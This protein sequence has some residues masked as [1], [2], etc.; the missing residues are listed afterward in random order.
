MDPSKVPTIRETHDAKLYDV[1]RLVNQQDVNW[2][3]TNMSIALHPT[4]GLSA[5]YRSS[6]YRIAANG[7]Y[8]VTIGGL[9]KNDV[10]FSELDK[11]FKPKNLRKLDV[12]SL[13]PKIVR[14]LEDAKLFYKNKNWYITCVTME[15]EH[16]EVARMAV[17][18]LD[19]KCTKVT[20]F[21]KF[22]GIDANRP[23]KN[24]MMPL[25]EN[26]PFDFMYGP[27]SIVRGEMLTSWMTD[28]QLVA[29]LRGNGHLIPLGDGTY[30]GVMHRTFY[31]NMNAYVSTTFGTSTNVIR[32][33]VHYF[34]RVDQ[35]GIINAISDGF[36]FHMPGVEFAGGLVI[37]NKEV[38]VSFGREDVSS[39]I[40]KMSLESVLKSLVEIEY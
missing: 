34:V 16:T 13:E 27:N 21:V 4:K 5:T 6:N 19:S 22:H 24:W 18:K 31:K 17:A 28:H 2:S 36:H 35:D 37:Y 8:E 14:G 32:D 7:R 3:A 12:S 40:A 30:L 25:E 1:L 10:W 9:I 33:Y 23:E 39:H 11:E 15:K 26:P 20:S 38:L 29:G